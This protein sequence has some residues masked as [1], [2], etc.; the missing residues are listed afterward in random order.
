LKQLL[1]DAGVASCLGPDN[2]YSLEQ[3]GS[4]FRGGVDF[5]ILRSDFER[6]TEATRGLF[7]PEPADEQVDYVYEARCPE[8]HS[9]EIVF[10]GR[11]GDPEAEPAVDARFNWTCDHCGHQ[12]T[13]D[14][15]QQD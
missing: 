2:L 11:E 1:E 5:K 10:M 15:I 14:G 8:C 12:W 6:A 4:E 9:T 3:F 7:P 13:D